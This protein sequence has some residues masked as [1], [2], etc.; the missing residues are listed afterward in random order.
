MKNGIIREDIFFHELV[1]K[2]YIM[3]HDDNL[4][5]ESYNGNLLDVDKTEDHKRY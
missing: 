2:I 4:G 1:I 5:I 3:S